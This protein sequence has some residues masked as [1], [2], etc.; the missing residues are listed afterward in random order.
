MARPAP[1]APLRGSGAPRPGLVPAK[2]RP[3]TPC[4]ACSASAASS[5]R[6]GRKASASAIGT[7]RLGVGVLPA[8]TGRP[9][10]ARAPRSRRRR[11]RPRAGG[12]RCRR[13]IRSRTP[14]GPLAPR[15]ARRGGRSPGAAAPST[16][17]PLRAF[18]VQPLAVHLDRRVG[19]RALHQLAHRYDGVGRAPGPCA[20]ARRRGP[21]CPSATP[22]APPPDRSWAA[23]AGSAARAWRVP[24]APRSRPV[25][26]GPACRRGPPSCPAA[27]S[28]APRPPRRARSSPAGLATRIT[29]GAPSRSRPLRR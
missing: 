8:R 27:A 20:R 6:S 18:A 10:C 11:G 9:W 21:R 5:G 14:P 24:P 3:V 13:C 17:S 16:A 26:K 25:A 29:P 12:R 2:R 15:A 23:R 19:R 28:G 7:T 4:A 22:A 1:A